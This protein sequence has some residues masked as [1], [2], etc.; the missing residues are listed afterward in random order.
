MFAAAVTL[1]ATL[2]AFQPAAPELEVPASDDRHYRHVVLPNG[3]PVVL[4]HTRLV[5]SAK[6]SAHVTHQCQWL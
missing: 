4:S 2:A 1:K 5:A 6:P 3:G